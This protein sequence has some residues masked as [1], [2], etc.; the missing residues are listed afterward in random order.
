MASK[1]YKAFFSA[2]RNVGFYR[3]SKGNI[4]HSSVTSIYAYLYLFIYLGFIK[5]Q[6]IV[7]L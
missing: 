1:V 7:Q 5:T 6:S 4:A 3:L 2:A